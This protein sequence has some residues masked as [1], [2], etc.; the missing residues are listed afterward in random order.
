MFQ[1]ESLIVAKETR[2]RRAFFSI[3]LLN[4]TPAAWSRIFILL[5]F[6]GLLALKKG[7]REGRARAR[8]GAQR[9]ASLAEAHGKVLFVGHGF[10]NTYIARE[11]NLPGWHGPKMPGRRYWGYGVYRKL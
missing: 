10:I 9:L 11:L 6:M 3:P 2:N 7:F 5:W 1:V 8:E 4:L